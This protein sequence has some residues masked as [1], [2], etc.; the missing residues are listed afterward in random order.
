LI[1]TLTVPV[2]PSL[3]NAYTNGRHHGRRVL[4]KEGRDYKD[5]VAAILLYK[6]KPASGF[7]LLIGR[8]DARIGLTLR[9]YFPNRQRRD[10]TNC[11]K[12]L[13]DALAETLGFDDCRVDR[14]LVERVGVDK[15]SPRC[16]VVVEV[17]GGVRLL[18]DER[19]AA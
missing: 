15:I 14:V 8:S 7:E 18:K 10:I 12:L 17:L 4:T 6:A 9:L 5:A 13:E 3:N 16:E 2:P 19:Q 11:I 1:L